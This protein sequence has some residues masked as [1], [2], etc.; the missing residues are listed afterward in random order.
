MIKTA[1]SSEVFDIYA[2]KMI[3]KRASAA[4][5]LAGK[6]AGYA[7]DLADAALL[8]GRNLDD[9]VV[10]AVRAE[11]TINSAAKSGA[12]IISELD[13]VMIG[14]KLDD[15]IAASHIEDSA[16]EILKV[17]S[18]SG[19][20]THGDDIGKFIGEFSDDFKRMAT[21]YDILTKSGP[22][23][24]AD[25]VKFVKDHQKAISFFNQLKDNTPLSKAISSQVV[26]GGR[27]AMS[28]GN[29]GVS[30][31]EA[32]SLATGAKAVDTAV[33]ISRAVGGI[34]TLATLGF[35]WQKSESVLD[36]FSQYFKSSEF[37]KYFEP[38]TNA[39]DCIKNIGLV[40][41]SDAVTERS[42]I[43]D[44]FNAY[45]ALKTM[46][47]NDPANKKIVE[48]A[49]QAATQLLATSGSGSIKGFVDLISS[50]PGDSL[51]G[52]YASTATG[53]ALGAGGGAFVGGPVGALIG[54]SIVGTAG[55][56]FLR[57]YYNSEIECILAAADA[58]KYLD[59]K[60]GVMSKGGKAEESAPAGTTPTPGESGPITPG[61]SADNIGFLRR[62]LAAGQNEKLIGIPG[63]EFVNEEKLTQAYVMGSGG[64][65]NAAEILLSKNA[66]ISAAI[67]QIRKS[68]PNN[69]LIPVDKSFKKDD[70][71]KQFLQ[72]LYTTMYQTFRNAV[73][74]KRKGGIFT[75]NLNELSQLMR[76]QFALEGITIKTSKNNWNKMNKSSN[77]INNQEFI[78]K[79][80][81]TRVS[82]FGD[83]N[84][85]LTD[86]LTKSYY[87]G[88]TGMY[89]EKPPK[90]TSDYKDLYGFQE[91]TG[92]DLILE[93]HPKSVTL[94]EAMG[95]G[96]LVENGLEQ[97]EKST[98]VALNTPTGNFQSKYASTIGYLNKLAKA[99]D[100]QGKKEV[101]RLIKQTI[102]NLK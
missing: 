96:G 32:T 48:G 18:N 89:N 37:D 51:S 7:D 87:A 88:L 82:Y 59:D 5:V 17:A 35:L 1:S 24:P 71:N 16:K 14:S 44:N 26:A 73:R 9:T 100:E 62:V 40:S 42:K 94:A 78:R 34:V 58:I 63:M 76:N 56:F 39:I 19:Y 66:N 38:I 47:P 67:D 22:V 13:S 93:A 75:P 68:N 43:I 3:S 79:A 83:A 54:A 28:A 95:K 33:T 21:E 53:A 97:K 4:T 57:V 11:P 77:S 27:A 30:L 8:L 46:T 65:D 45:L 25:A 31:T 84:S 29:A 85:G 52:F 101:S 36:Y 81:E 86:Q 6:L 102:Q 80:A 92:E 90:R 2:K 10:Q 49:S 72:I 12:K 23:K 15:L 70:I 74:G 99:A 41:G 50:S 55:A 69:L 91:E 61:I 20:T 64:L 60:L 98:Y